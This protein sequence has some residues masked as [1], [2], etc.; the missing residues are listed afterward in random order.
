MILDCVKY[1][2]PFK[3]STLYG[4]TVGSG[5]YCMMSVCITLI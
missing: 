2:K 5:M 1:G 3:V 4:C